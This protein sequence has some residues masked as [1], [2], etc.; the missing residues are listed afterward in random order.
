[1]FSKEVDLT[2]L[3]TPSVNT[4]TP[5]NAVTTLIAAREPPRRSSVPACGMAN[6]PQR[7]I[8]VPNQGRCASAPITLYQ[9]PAALQDLVGLMGKI[10]TIEETGLVLARPI[11]SPKLAWPMTEPVRPQILK[12]AVAR[13]RQREVSPLVSSPTLPRSTLITSESGAFGRVHYNNL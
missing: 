4:T 10:L 2:K 11:P 5:N 3:F 12:P 1:M 13:N 6:G 7:I 9:D 8:S